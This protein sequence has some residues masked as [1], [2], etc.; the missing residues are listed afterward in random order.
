M[1]HNGW[2]AGVRA[3]RPYAKF[4]NVQRD[5]KMKNTGMTLRLLLG[6]VCFKLVI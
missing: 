2:Q 4:T 6:T 1:P 3:G 5:F